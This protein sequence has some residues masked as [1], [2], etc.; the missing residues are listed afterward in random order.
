LPLATRREIDSRLSACG[1]AWLYREANVLERTTHPEDKGPTPLLARQYGDA[2]EFEIL[3]IIRVDHKPKTLH[4][5]SERAKTGVVV[6]IGL[7]RRKQIRFES[8]SKLTTN[9]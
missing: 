3:T 5:T 2:I 4:G 6:D 7:A 9:E 1:R 8:V